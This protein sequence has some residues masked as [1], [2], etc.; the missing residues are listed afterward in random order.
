MLTL[1]VAG[2]ARRSLLV[3]VVLAGFTPPLAAAQPLERGADAL[4]A[5]DQHRA[6]VV[7]HVVNA[8]GA[9][10]AKSPAQISIDELRTRLASLRADTLLAASLAGTLDGLR[11]V[12]GADDVSIA[13]A[14]P[15]LTQTKALGDSAADVVYTP[16]TPCRL[17]E[18]R[19]AFAAVYQ[20]DG[21]AGHTAVPF[22]S[23]QIRTYTLQGGNG[24]CL[25]QL[26]AG[27]N[28]SAV[29]LQVFGIPTTSA[30]GDIEILPQGASF[31][32]TATM[33]YVATIPFNTVSTAAKANLANHQISVQ[34]RGGGAHVAI[35]VVGYFAA[36]S[37]S[38]GK[39][40]MQGGNAF[41]TTATLGTSDNQPLNINVN[42]QRVMRYE[43]NA[44]TPNV[45]GGNANN[46]AN[47]TFEAQ[48]IAGGGL[49]GNTCSD[50][51]TLSNRSCGNRTA[52]SFATIGGGLANV[53]SN[54]AASVAG[55]VS[56]TAS[57]S[58]GTVAGGANNTASGFLASV[59]GGLDNTA[60]GDY[61]TVPG[62]YYNTAGIHS[63]AAGTEAN[64]WTSGC[65]VWADS[66]SLNPTS[67]FQN[68]EFVARSV[69]GF[70]FF[71]AGS[72]DA[73][74]TGAQLLPGAGAWSVYSDR[75]S[76][77]N[78]DSVDPLDVLKKLA[79]VPIATW[80]WSAQGEGIRHMGPMAQDFRAAFGLGESEKA[81]STVDADGVA[82]AA[83]QGL[84]AIVRAG[85]SRADAQTHALD[86]AQNELALQRRQI[87]ELQQRAGDV[88]A[89]R[90]ELATLKAAL[91]AAEAFSKARYDRP[92]AR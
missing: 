43:L 12:I 84:H 14:K 37:G 29:Q 24:V 81:I 34:V 51:T 31:G 46:G 89:L 64:A 13:A 7:E 10:L 68:N 58:Y 30:S 1:R 36:P 79:A 23:N 70:F 26:P 76:K 3:L 85:Q 35:D 17:V 15:G 32:S 86:D 92:T 67:C 74:Y 82:L 71:T 44:S 19:G 4:L 77:R 33:V 69:G 73:T 87:A 16:V 54:L 59:G 22:A 56:N 38:G 80:N 42:G 78:I 27:L 20:G 65:F 40:F 91:T 61:G 55:G 8:W 18:T 45:I 9:A 72:S 52:R 66:S 21:S 6:S 63:F 48:T 83:I 11:E 47:A 50:P 49:P 62:G 5:I 39:F 41:G 90:D 75:A 25:T 2:C 53:A 88:A 60:S 28:A 57:G